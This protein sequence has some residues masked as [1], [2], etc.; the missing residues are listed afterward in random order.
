MAAQYPTNVVS[1]SPS[2]VT[3]FTTTVLAE[4]VNTLREEM[5]SVQTNLGTSITT[6][7]GWVGVFDQTTASWDSLKDRIANIEYGIKEVWDAVPAGG[8]D[9]QVLTKTSNSDYVT[10]WATIDVLPSQSGNSGKYLTTDGSSATWT[11]V[12][13]NDNIISPFLLAGC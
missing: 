6:G 10:A 1:F 8:S 9:G 13:P 3:D 4:H 5:I 7:S 11:L 12:D 2:T